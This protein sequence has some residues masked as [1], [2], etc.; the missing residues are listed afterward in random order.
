MRHAQ[1]LKKELLQV[2][3]RLLLTLFLQLHPL[4]WK[5]M[6]QQDAISWLRALEE[7]VRQIAHNAGYEGSIVIDRL[8]NA[9]LGTGF[10][11]A[12]GEWVNMIEAGIIDQ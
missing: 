9:E 1:R 12:T 3:V 11:A 5:G 2:V 10:N 7:P 8:K 6:K 4:N